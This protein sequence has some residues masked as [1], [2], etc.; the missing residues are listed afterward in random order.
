[1]PSF[2][3]VSIASGS[4]TPSMRQNTASL[5]IGM[6][7]R[8]ETKPG[9]SL[10]S[11]AVFPSR[12][13]SATV[14]PV[15]ASLV[16]SPRI[17]STSFMTGTGFMKCMPMTRSGLSTPEAISVIEMELVFV[18]RIVSGPLTSPS[19]AKMSCFSSAFS[20][21]AS[22][23]SWASLSPAGSVVVRMRARAPSASPAEIFSFLT[24]LWRLRSIVPLAPSRAPASTST[25]STSRPAIEQTWAIPFPIVPAPTT[26]TLCMVPPSDT[27]QLLSLIARSGP[28]EASTSFIR[29]AS[30]TMRHAPDTGAPWTASR[31]AAEARARAGRALAAFG[32]SPRRCRQASLRSQSSWLRARKT[33]R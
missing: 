2:I 25:I 16:S 1:M 20:G 5:I 27:S 23:T 8:L 7:I 33:L 18:A 12:S 24:C 19:R 10:T 30:V 31:P 28:S 14:T 9:K 6:R 17:T 26:P 11:T 15:V 3:T 22:T 29:H 13:H 4:A 21:T 32:S